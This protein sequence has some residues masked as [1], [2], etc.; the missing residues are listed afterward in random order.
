MIGPLVAGRIDEDAWGPG[1]VT[2]G[3]PF[4]GR[5][6]TA[7]RVRR[8]GRT[9][10]VRVRVPVASAAAAAMPVRWLWAAVAMLGGVLT[11]AALQVAG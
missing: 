11:L 8:D 10:S 1:A 9:E 6:A 5:T 4:L 3:L 2:A 7:L